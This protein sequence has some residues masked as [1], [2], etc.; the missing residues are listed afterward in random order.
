MEISAEGSDNQTGFQ[1]R[2]AP[3]E[4]ASELASTGSEHHDSLFATTF[5]R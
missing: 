5:I 3:A 1:S 2:R 4:R